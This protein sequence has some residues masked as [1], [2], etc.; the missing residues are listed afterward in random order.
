[1]AGVIVIFVAFALI[2]QSPMDQKEETLNKALQAISSSDSKT[3]ESSM[4]IL[5]THFL[6]IPLKQW[7]ILK[8]KPN[9]DLLN[10]N[11]GAIEGWIDSTEKRLQLFGIA[12]GGLLTDNETVSTALKRVTLREEV[13]LETRMAAFESLCFSQ[14]ENVAVLNENQIKGLTKE[15]DG[16]SGSS[17]TGLAL[18]S[19]RIADVLIASGHTK[20]ELQI[21]ASTCKNKVSS[22][23]SILFCLSVLRRFDQE[24][25]PVAHSLINGLDKEHEF[26]IDILKVALDVVGSLDL[27]RDEELGQSERVVLADFLNRRIS[28]KS[29]ER[30][31]VLKGIEVDPNQFAS[32]F[33]WQLVHGLEVTK[34]E[35]LRLLMSDRLAKLRSRLAKEIKLCKESDD[36]DTASLAAAVLDKAARDAEK[37]SGAKN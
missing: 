17:I 36:E 21:L 34:R 11:T 31:N 5:S 27:I 25:E 2:F 16:S 9:I 29:E 24:A 13:A 19:E 4:E 33:Q 22:K 37:V 35:T 28:E 30:D 26:R 1:M 18:I 3:Q 32:I 20:S 6:S 15:F 14:N 23:P 10:R 12:I 8:D 7:H